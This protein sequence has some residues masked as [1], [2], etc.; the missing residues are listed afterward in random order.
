M[1]PVYRSHHVPQNVT[2]F[3]FHLV[4]DM[5][6]KQFTYLALGL[7]TAYLLFIFLTKSAPIIAWP[8]IVISALLGVAFA[9]LPI[10]ERPL[11]YWLAAFLKAVFR[12]T[13]RVYLSKNMAVNSPLFKYRLGSYLQ[14][15][16]TQSLQS[17]TL[18]QTPKSALFNLTAQTI[19]KKLE[20]V[21][22]EQVLQR[23]IKLPQTTAPPIKQALPSSE[24]LS[25]TVELAKEAQKVQT[26]IMQTEQQLNQIKSSAA[27]VG[28]NQSQFVDNFKGLLS[29]LDKLN[30]EA[31]DVSHELAV[32][33]KTPPSLVSK[34]PKKVVSSAINLT[35]T[36]FPN[37]ING[38]VT[39]SAGN[40]LEG[41]IIVAHDKTG[42]PVRALKTNKLGQFVAATP[43][44]NGVYDISIE[45]DSLSFDT[46]ELELTGNILKPVA[47]AAK[48]VGLS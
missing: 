5:T 37:I 4:G 18:E 44:A 11:D 35:L 24:D 2:S 32:L 7:S 1:E 27:A 38:I 9:F 34:L 42:I 15:L 47:I 48:R 19:A 31:S 12:P 29:E 8:L 26:Q 28:A 13:K 10:A 43:L 23:D 14:N 36:T 16:A 45:K 21:A 3:E 30:Q 46:I 20:G 40:Y 41:A 33:S 17:P 25:K 22:P 39:D 6:L